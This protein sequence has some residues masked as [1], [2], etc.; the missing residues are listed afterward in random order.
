MPAFTFDVHPVDL[1][2]VIAFFREN[3]PPS[4][5]HGLRFELQPGNPIAAVLEPWERRFTLRD[6]HY[7]GYE[8]S[9]RLWGRKRLELLAGIL[10]YAQQV[11]VGVLGRALPHI[12]V[13]SCGPY[14]FLLVLSG[15]TGSEWS[16]DVAFDLMAPLGSPDPDELDRVHAYLSEHLAARPEQIATDTGL[17]QRE[18]EVILF[19]LCRAGR[20][21]IDP[22]SRQYR[23]RELFAAPLDLD[24]LFAPDPRVA[25][26]RRLVAQGQVTLGR[27]TP[28]EENHTRPNETRAEATV[29][30]GDAIYDV[31]V[32][33]DD[34]DRLRFGRCG[35]PFFVDNMVSLGPCVHIQAARLALEAA[36]P[37]QAA[38]RR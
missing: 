5:P 27:V 37:A 10:P 32:A 25:A 23:L 14:R 22:T 9:V 12:Y 20:A 7:T 6:T 18:V 2:S 16:R 33:V 24:L 15:W 3:R 30:D 36:T 11:T 17:S 31:I 19:Q 34:S 8:R 1:L 21:M 13:C 4:P 26:A 38:S 29:R 35:C 28:P